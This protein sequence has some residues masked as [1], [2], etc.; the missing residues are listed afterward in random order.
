MKKIEVNNQDLGLV[1]TIDTYGMFD[2]E[3]AIEDLIDWFNEQHD[4]NYDYDDFEWDYDHAQIVKDFAEKRAEFLESESPAIHKCVP[5]STG[6]PREYNFSTDYAIY[7]ITYD[8][9]AVDKYVKDNQQDYDK[10]YR[11]SGW[12][13]HTEWRDDDDKQKE[14]N[15]TISKLDYYLNK[16]ID[17][18]DAFN[19]LFECET[20]VYENNIKMNA[21]KK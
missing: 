13:E 14:E 21:I 7:E 6:S 1:A 20:E 18:D 10:W 11:E 9:E 15:R 19:A 2:S 5:V 12:Y 4:T 8:D 16:T 3:N 17:N